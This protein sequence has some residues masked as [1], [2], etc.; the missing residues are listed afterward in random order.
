MVLYSVAARALSKNRT[1][2]QSA[3][4]PSKIYT[5]EKQDLKA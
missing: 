5:F 3:N 1:L 4:G 2:E